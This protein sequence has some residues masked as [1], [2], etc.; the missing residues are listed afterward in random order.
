METLRG[1]QP[2]GAEIAADDPPKVGWIMTRERSPTTFVVT[3]KPT[4]A[5]IDGIRALRAVLKFALRRFG[6]RCTSA[7]EVCDAA[8]PDEPVRTPAVLT[9]GAKK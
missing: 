8:S 5:G 2:G 4:I 6:L 3:L 1:R 9:D 7:R